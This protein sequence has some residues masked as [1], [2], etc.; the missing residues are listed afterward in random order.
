MNKIRKYAV[1]ALLLAFA[2]IGFAQQDGM[3]DYVVF[4]VEDTSPAIRVRNG[5]ADEKLTVTWI[6]GDSAAVGVVIGSTSNNLDLSGTDDTVAEVAAL[7]DDCTNSAGKKVLDVDYNCSLG[8]DSTDDETL[9][10][11]TSTARPGKWATVAKWDTSTAKFYSCY[12]PGGNVANGATKGGF[13]GRRI[14]RKIFGNIGG[15]GD[16]T[17]N[18]YEDGTEVFEQFIEC[19]RYIWSAAGTTETWAADEASPAQ[20]ASFDPFK[21][22]NFPCE[23]GKDYM[24]RATRATTGTTGSIGAVVTPLK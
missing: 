24:I 20:L 18:I 5:D 21:A 2:A 16:I 4:Q 17:V 13:Q 14:I 23:A 8:A 15:T 22:I 6:A 19:P 9:D 3:Q 1:T 10:S 7:F 11:V 12:I